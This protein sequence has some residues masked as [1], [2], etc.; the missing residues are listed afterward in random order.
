MCV[1]VC[2]CVGGGGTGRRVTE[3]QNYGIKKL[4]KVKNY[5]HSLFFEKAG[6]T[7]K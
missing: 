4:R 5:V 1:C 3:L 7:I 2:V 6:S